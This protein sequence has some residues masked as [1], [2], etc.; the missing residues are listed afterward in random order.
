M[1]HNMKS[2]EKQTRKERHLQRWA[3]VLSTMKT[4][5]KT[6]A[7]KKKNTDLEPVTY[8]EHE[9]GLF[10]YDVDVVA[11]SCKDKFLNARL[12][13]DLMDADG[14][15]L[16]KGTW[17]DVHYRSTHFLVCSRDNLPCVSVIVPVRIVPMAEMCWL[18]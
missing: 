7:K 1:W 8:V 13:V 12:L 16:S 4:S 10:E 15:L 6:S 5:C 9:S 2:R 11:P 18:C 3:D 14:V 17:I